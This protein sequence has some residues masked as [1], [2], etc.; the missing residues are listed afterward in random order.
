MIGAHK[1]LTSAFAR[2][3][4]K[5]TDPFNRYEVR[6]EFAEAADRIIKREFRP[7]P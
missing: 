7:R 1:R 3:A 5:N 6:R 2:P 4:R